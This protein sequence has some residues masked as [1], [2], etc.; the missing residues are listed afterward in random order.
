M[1]F[2]TLKNALT[3]AVIELLHSLAEYATFQEQQKN[4]HNRTIIKMLVCSKTLN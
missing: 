1:S 3:C 2:T 4:L